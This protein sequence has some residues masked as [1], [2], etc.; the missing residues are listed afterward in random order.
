VA[1]LDILRAFVAHSRAGIPPRQK[2]EGRTLEVQVF[3]GLQDIIAKGFSGAAMDDED[4]LLATADLG[5]GRSGS[6]NPIDNAYAMGQRRLTLID[7]SPAGLGLEGDDAG[8]PLE[9]GTVIAIR[10]ESLGSPI[11]C[12][13]VRRMPTPGEPTRLGARVLCR[14]MRHVRLVSPDKSVI[15]TIFV[16]GEDSSG[17]ND[18]FLLSSSDFEPDAVL[19]LNFD[20]R[21]YRIRLN[22]IFHRGR[23]WVLAKLEVLDAVAPGAV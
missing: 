16:A 10:S 21:T 11:L 13:I 5:R 19:D 22:R 17:R 14:D 18:A 8:A 23:G 20:N 7:E 15:E 3:V 4:G 2:R 1:V 6:G 9:A 12:E